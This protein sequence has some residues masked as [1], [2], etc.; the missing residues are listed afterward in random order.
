MPFTPAQIKYGHLKSYHE[1]DDVALVARIAKAPESPGANGTA[2][3]KSEIS[4]ITHTLKRYYRGVPSIVSGRNAVAIDKNDVFYDALQGWT[5]DSYGFNFRELIDESELS[6]EASYLAIYDFVFVGGE[7]ESIR[8]KFDYIGDD[9]GQDDG[10]LP[11]AGGNDGQDGL[12][13]NWR[14]DWNALASYQVN[15]VVRLD[16]V[17]YVAVAVNSASQPEVD[18]SNTNWDVMVEGGATGGSSAVS[19]LFIQTATVTVSNTTTETTV[20][21]TSGALGTLPIASG[22]FLAGDQFKVSAWGRFSTSAPDAGTLS[23][24]VE[25]GTEIVADFDPLDLPAYQSAQPWFVTLELVRRSEGSSGVVSGFGMLVV[26]VQG[27][28]PWLVPVVIAPTVLPS[29]AAKTPNVT[30]KWSVASVDNSF[31]CYGTKTEH[32]GGPSA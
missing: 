13:F 1:G 22:T 16:N 24:D 14:E 32:M 9:A 19:A 15:D 12:G 11:P 31:V 26:G 4:S 23:I 17:V 25:L 29:D 3:L 20:V 8:M 28:Q 6:P 21:S 30:A 27:N 5:E 10:E 18:D 7:S 2:F